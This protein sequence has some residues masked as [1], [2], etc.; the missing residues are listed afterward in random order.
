MKA[1]ISLAQNSYNTTTNYSKKLLHRGYSNCLS[2]LLK[3][4][5]L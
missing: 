2:K 4:H 1:L 3:R 5:S